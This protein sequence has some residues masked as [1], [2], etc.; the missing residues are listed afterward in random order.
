MN[1]LS[2]TTYG[3][4]SGRYGGAWRRYR[5]DD[6]AAKAIRTIIERRPNVAEYIDDVYFGA[7][8]QAGE[9]DPQR[10][11]RWRCSWPGCPDS[12]PVRASIDCAARG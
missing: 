4:R 1:D 3:R 2:S 6:L 11:P 7:T 12:Y 9:D 5:T 10:R 8:N